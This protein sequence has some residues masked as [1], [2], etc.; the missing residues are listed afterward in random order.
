MRSV[1]VFMGSIIPAAGDLGNPWRGGEREARIARSCCH[2]AGPI[3]GRRGARVMTSE[4]PVEVYAARDLADAYIVRE[5]L[6]EAG[7]EAT[8]MGEPLGMVAGKVPPLGVTPRIWVRGED[9]DRA[10]PLIEQHRQR[11]AT[12]GSDGPFCY[13]CGEPVLPLA[14]E[15]PNCGKGLEWGGA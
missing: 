3:N 1:V 10:R 12:R 2:Q 14:A 15:C 5:M 13:H 4:G 8:V 6:A 9:A 7:V 11:A